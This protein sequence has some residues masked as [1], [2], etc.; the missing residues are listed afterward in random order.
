MGRYAIGLDYVGQPTYEVSSELSRPLLADSQYEVD[1]SGDRRRDHRTDELLLRLN[2]STGTT[3][4]VDTTGAVASSVAGVVADTDDAP[5][6]TA[7][8]ER[9]LRAYDA[10]SG[11]LPDRLWN[12]ASVFD[13]LKLLEFDPLQVA[14]TVKTMF[15]ESG[16]PQQIASNADLAPQMLAAAQQMAGVIAP[17]GDDRQLRPAGAGRQLLEPARVRCRRPAGQGRR[18]R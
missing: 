12:I 11:V 8:L 4:Y 7:E 5:F 10:D 2:P 6:A 14:T 3:E 13:P 15:N 16:T 9:I 18:R 17:A 1:L